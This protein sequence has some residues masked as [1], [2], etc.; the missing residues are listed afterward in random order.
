MELIVISHPEA[1]DNEAKLINLLFAAGMKRFHLRKP[2]ATPVEL[3]GLLNDIDSAYLAHVALHQHYELA[4]QFPISRFH[5]PAKVRLDAKNV[6]TEHKST[7]FDSLSTSIHDLLEL[8][9]LNNYNYAFFSPVFDSI[10]KPEYKRNVPE[11]FSLER[12]DCKARIIALGG[13]NHTNISQVKGMNFDGAAVLGSVWLGGSPVTNFL[14][15]N[16]ALN[17]T[18]NDR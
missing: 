8:Q 12:G 6:M 2:F 4:K 7:G 10:S 17:A 5:H 11:D 14:Q 9:S 18:N 3:T 15:L 16:T 13:I 1:I